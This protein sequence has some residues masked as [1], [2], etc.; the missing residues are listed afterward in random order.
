MIASLER[1]H[2]HHVLKTG[3]KKDINLVRFAAIYGANAAGKSNL[4]K[5][6][7][8]ARNLVVRGLRADA[9]I[10]VERFRLDKTCLKRPAHFE[11]EFKAGGKMYEYGFELDS[12]RINREWL[13]TFTRQSDTL[14]F[15]RTTNSDG[16]VEVKTG[17]FTNKLD[18]EEQLF[19]QFVSKGTRPNQ[20]Y[21]HECIERNV[22][23]FR[24]AYEWF[25]SV[26]TII[27]PTSSYVPV[28][29]Q[30]D[31]DETFQE[32]FGKVL[33]NADT[34]IKSITS[35]DIDCDGLKNLSEEAL[36]IIQNNLKDDADAIYLKSPSGL[37]F[38]GI[39][40]GD[41]IRILKLV[42]VH[43]ATESSEEA[44][45]DIY[46]ES[47]GTQRLID[48]IPLLYELILGNDERVF[49]VDEIER[50][51]HPKLSRM[52]LELHLDEANQSKL[53]QLIVTT[54]ETN[55]LD[56][57]LLRRDE[58]WFVEKKSTTGA[59]EI[60]S[61]H[62]FQP[63]YDKDVLKDYLYGRYGAIPFL[64]NIHALRLSQ[65]KNK[66]SSRSLDEDKNG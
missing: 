57:D 6:I 19:L 50:S 32:F 17:S 30:M 11:I 53:S 66:S 44:N 48:L 15:E 25:R 3:K 36:E 41:N 24:E 7:K 39:K 42:A 4:V 13:L 55:I 45:F 40:D 51:L 62:D 58:I 63:R 31:E 46:E 56:L 5:A 8:F 18:K 2:S 1:I 59:T 52:M 33:R 54:H 26:L 65:A 64:G 21:L 9:K 61:L 34:G 16:K 37:R 12:E 10:P 60:Y 14:L 22:Q 43:Q 23:Y 29:L 20:L 28:E 35:E 47:D 38:T 49:V 27:E